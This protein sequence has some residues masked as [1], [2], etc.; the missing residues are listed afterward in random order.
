MIDAFFHVLHGTP[1]GPP[2]VF[3]CLP[4]GVVGHLDPGYVG[5][6]PPLPP[7]YQHA[8]VAGDKDGSELLS[9]PYV[10]FNSSFLYGQH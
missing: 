4:G 1:A 2:S 8:R 3:R 10:K 6:P 7:A 9:F 5:P